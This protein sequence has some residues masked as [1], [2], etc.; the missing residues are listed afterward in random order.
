[1]CGS[2]GSFPPF[3]IIGTKA[4]CPSYAI[5]PP[6]TVAE[7]LGFH[8]RTDIVV[9]IEVDRRHQSEEPRFRLLEAA[10]NK[11][12]KSWSIPNPANLRLASTLAAGAAVWPSD[13][14]PIQPEI[15]SV[16]MMDTRVIHVA[17]TPGANL[18]NRPFR[19]A[20]TPGTRSA[21]LG[22][23]PVQRMSLP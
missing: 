7:M 4:H 6:V 18:I 11:R 22:S 14:A 21:S 16:L 23:F 12:P 8:S 10:G 3:R 20:P 1:M 5:E 15:L 13:F 19:S 17:S 2:K 9:D